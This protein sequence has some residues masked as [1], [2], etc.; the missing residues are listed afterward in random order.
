M[1][2][3]NPVSFVTTT[4]I[5]GLVFLVPVVVITMILAQALEFMMM[6]AQPLAAW[7]PVDTIGGVALANILA[8]VA[9]VLVCFIGGLIARSGVV[10]N[11]VDTLETKILMKVPGYV[12]IKGMFS[13]LSDTANQ[14]LAP[15]LVAF[16][17]ASRVG[18]E[19]ERTRDGHVVVSLPRSPNPW[20]GE[21][22]ILPAERVRRLDLSMGWYVEYVERF[23]QGSD[24]V[25]P[26]TTGVGV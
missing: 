24:A 3:K 2:G 10:R 19:I 26:G 12:L 6:V 13:G 15:V 21:V 18:L 11:V 22:F 17:D 20:S 16:G 5:G 14:Q 25:L 9:L 7:F 23:G 4:V 8:A 1:S